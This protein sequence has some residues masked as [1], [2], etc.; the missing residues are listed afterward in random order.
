MLLKKKSLDFLFCF[1]HG[2]NPTS[3]IIL[4]QFIII[5]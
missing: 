4:I 3:L 1:D 2:I 5:I